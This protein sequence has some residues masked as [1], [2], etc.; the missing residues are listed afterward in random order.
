MTTAAP[1][2]SVFLTFSNLLKG[3]VDLLRS[4]VP[5]NDITLVRY[6]GPQGLPFEPLEPPG[7]LMRGMIVCPSV[8][9]PDVSVL[10]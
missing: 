3:Q 9:E 10:A 7:T 5:R 1:L 4:D 2:E 8:S 6:G